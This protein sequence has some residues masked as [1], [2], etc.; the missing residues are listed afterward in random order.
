MLRSVK[1]T[2]MMAGR[3]AAES[4]SLDPTRLLNLLQ[5]VALLTSG[6]W[7][8]FKYFDYEEKTQAITL[9]QQQLAYQ[10]AQALAE[11]QEKTEVARLKQLE[12]SNSQAKLQVHQQRLTNEQTALSL[13]VAKAQR[14]LRQLE[15]E[16]T[17]QLREQEVEIKRL[18]RTKLS[19]EI[20]RTGQYQV[21]HELSIRPQKVR[22]IGSNS[23]LHEVKLRIDF[24][25]NSQV[26]IKVP[27]VIVEFYIG[28]VKQDS[29]KA[30]ATA[31]P[32][33]S[34]GNLWGAEASEGTVDWVRAGR[35]GSILSDVAYIDRFATFRRKEY[36]TS[37][38]S[39]GTGELRQGAPLT[40]GDALIVTAPPGAYIGVMVNWCYNDC[41]NSTEMWSSW[42]WRN[43][44]DTN[45]S[46]SERAEKR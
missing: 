27:M 38:N 30:V 16:R 22:D 36:G 33:G 32:L 19:N 25:N 8:L 23:E 39:G 29:S 11:T 28:T 34:P 31:S 13:L 5:A 43:L 4:T 12:L 21:S 41:N 15:L 9:K 2:K 45:R 26:I 20:D 37:I 46:H 24:A 35:M 44:T 40:F 10:Q 17:V 6:A 14:D 3:K 7:V 18:E 42:D 1:H